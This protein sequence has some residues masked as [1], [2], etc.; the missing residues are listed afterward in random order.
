[1]P[2]TAKRLRSMSWPPPAPPLQRN[3]GSSPRAEAP[4]AHARFRALQTTNRYPGLDSAVASYENVPWKDKPSVRLDAAP[5]QS[6]NPMPHY[7]QPALLRQPIGWGCDSLGS[8]PETAQPALRR[9]TPGFAASE[10]AR[11]QRRH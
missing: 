9:Q 11:W 3:G 4:T 7:L 2:S 8:E 5:R 1:M 6:G 10:T